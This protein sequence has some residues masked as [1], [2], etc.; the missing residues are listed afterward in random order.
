[1]RHRLLAAALLAAGGIFASAGPALADG[2]AA[3]GKVVFGRCAA[4]HSL[5]AGKKLM[6]PNLNGIVG[7]KAGA[8]AGYQYSKAMASSG[9]TWDDATLDKFLASPTSTVPGTKMLVNV[10]NAQDRA[11]AIAYLK[12]VK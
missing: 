3:H 8:V 12:T 11:D 4:C 6:G 2:D 5:D 1:M 9:L 10:A 7:Q